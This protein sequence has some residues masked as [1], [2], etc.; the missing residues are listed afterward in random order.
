MAV[1]GRI[2]KRLAFKDLV[3][4]VPGSNPT[5]QPKII[6]PLK[7]QSQLLSVSSYPK[8]VFR[9]AASIS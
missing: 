7:G 9:I 2:M 1:E 5:R 6:A 3:D 4:S 8:I